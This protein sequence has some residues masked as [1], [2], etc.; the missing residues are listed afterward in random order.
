MWFSGV[1]L[2]HCAGVPLASFS[3]STKTEE[4]SLDQLV[5]YTKILIYSTVEAFLQESVLDPCKSIHSE[6]TC[7][8]KAICPPQYLYMA[9]Q[10]R[11]LSVLLQQHQHHLGAFEMQNLGG[12]KVNLGSA[13]HSLSLQRFPG[14]YVHFQ[15]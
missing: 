10:L 7:A 15:V 12:E 13:N 2:T 11:L 9:C 5:S 14:A 1:G 8:V 6:G 4:K 3:S